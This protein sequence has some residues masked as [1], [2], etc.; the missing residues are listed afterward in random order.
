MRIERLTIRVVDI[1]RAADTIA[2]PAIVSGVGIVDKVSLVFAVA[3]SHGTDIF[4][5]GGGCIQAKVIF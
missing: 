4:R 2:I 1:A 3:A 5:E